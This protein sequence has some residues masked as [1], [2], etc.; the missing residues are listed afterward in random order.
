[1]QYEAIDAQT[2]AELLG[3]SV[4]QINNYINLKGL[5]SQ[6][7]GR[8]RTFVWSEVLDW[9]VGYRMEMELGDGSGGSEEAD[10]EETTFGN[11]RREDIRAA[12]LRKT[13]A[14]ADL[15]ELALARQ[16]KE[17]IVIVDARDKLERMMGS[18][19]AKLLGLTPRLA[20]RVEAARDRQ[21]REDAIREEIENVCREISTGAVIEGEDAPAEEVQDALLES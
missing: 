8:R 6:G 5:P 16:R 3:V 20:A 14:D 15:R 10:S 7:E 19:R 18:L 1:M 4:R 11:G 21:V 2:V 12:N 9:Y 17:V 13:K